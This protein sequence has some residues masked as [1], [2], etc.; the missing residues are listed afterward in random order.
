[1]GS[2]S[3]LRSTGRRV[4]RARPRALHDPAERACPAPARF[5]RGSSAT[6]SPLVAERAAEPSDAIPVRTDDVGTPF[7]RVAP[8]AAGARSGTALA[9]WNAMCRVERARRERRGS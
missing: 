1:M 8:D 2:K 7:V 3:R 4:V 5:A 9:T 6:I